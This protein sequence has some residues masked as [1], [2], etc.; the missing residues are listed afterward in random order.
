MQNHYLRAGPRG[1][2]SEFERN[3]PASDKR[4]APGEPLEFQE[5]LARCH[6]LFAGDFQR[7]RPTDFRNGG[8]DAL[9]IR[10]GQRLGH[11]HA[12]RA[13]EIGSAAL[14]EARH[15][16]GFQRVERAACR[17]G[18]CRHGLRRGPQQADRHGLGAGFRMAE[19]RNAR[20]GQQSQRLL[21]R[22]RQ[23]HGERLG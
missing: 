3:V 22:R 4:D 1:D 9:R 21:G 13:E 15:A 6:A 14:V 20:R 19:G 7:H 16:A 10:D 5:L 23:R 8:S 18:K 11:R 2:V 17:L 12:Q